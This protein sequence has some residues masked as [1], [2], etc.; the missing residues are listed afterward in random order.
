MYRLYKDYSIKNLNISV[1]K[2]K[3]FDISM[4]GLINDLFIKGTL[5][6]KAYHKNLEDQS[7]ADYEIEK[8]LFID[9]FKS[10]VDE[11]NFFFININ[12]LDIQF[13]T[14]DDCTVD[15]IATIPWFNIED[16]ESQIIKGKNIWN[17]V[18]SQRILK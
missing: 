16:R 6:N 8:I 14:T 10:L 11:F 7:T 4:R 13:K 12:N 15:F 1:V 2:G 3:A 18:K 17:S 9:G 5:K